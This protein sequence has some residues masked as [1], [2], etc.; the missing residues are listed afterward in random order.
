MLSWHCG[1]TAFWR[2]CKLSACLPN[3]TCLLPIFALPCSYVDNLPPGGV[4]PYAW[5]EPTQRNQ[6][7]VQVGGWFGRMSRQQLLWEI[8]GS[9]SRKQLPWGIAAR[10]LLS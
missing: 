1:S 5:D 4:M 2:L 9:M 6:I 10:S 7:R 3:L 8:A